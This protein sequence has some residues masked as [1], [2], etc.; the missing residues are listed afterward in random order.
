MQR[1]NIYHRKDGRWEGRI[2]RGKKH[3]GSRKYQYI[4]GNSKEQVCSKIIQIRNSEQK[5]NCSIEFESIFNEWISSAKHRVKESTLSNYILKAN[6]HILPFFGS[7]GISAITSDYV[8]AFI[9][10]K[11]KKGLSNRYILDILIVLKSVFKYAVRIYHIY[12]PM[13]GVI[14]PKRG[15]TE[16]RLLEKA[17]QEEL[18]KYI[19]VN[20]NH[21]TM[22][23]ALSMTTGIRIGELCALQWKDIDLGKH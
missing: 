6:K 5:N 14:M 15:N 1:F 8:Y 4:F 11:Q 3:N 19:S 23:I 18:Q 16:I 17:E 22:G 7:K 9:Q 13:D 2:A 20:K 10:D 21:T 12:N